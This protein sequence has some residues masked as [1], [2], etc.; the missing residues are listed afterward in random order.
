VNLGLHDRVALVTGSSSGIG[1]SVVQL[2]AQEGAHVAITYRHQAQPALELAEVINATGAHAIVV[3]YD[4]ASVESIRH[5]MQTTVAK[6]GRLDVLVNNAVDFGSNAVVDAPMFENWPAEE[7]RSLLR[8][9]LEGAIF[10]IQL[11]LPYLRRNKWGRIVNVS[12]TLAED[13]QPGSAWYGTAKAGLNGLTQSLA[14]ELGP[15]GIL[16]NSVM[17]GP[18]RTSRS[19]GISPRV[20][21]HLA[22]SMAVRRLLEPMDVASVIVFLCSATNVAITG[23]TIRIGGRSA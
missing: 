19:H 18:T 11:A 6:W 10:T 5:A 17:P 4:L 9:N 1:H 13:G 22:H 14:K 8:N 16:I 21:Q 12:S 23:E 15:F 7:W 2:L 20:Q 3:E